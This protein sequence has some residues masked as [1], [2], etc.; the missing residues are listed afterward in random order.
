VPD[1]SVEVRLGVRV[2]PGQEPAALER[3]IASEGR[4]A[5]R[6]LYLQV[7]EAKDDAAVK[8]AMGSRQRREPRWVATIFGRVRIHRYRVK[9]RTKSFHPLDKELGLHRSEPSRALRALTV[10]LAARMSYRDI[11]MA[12]S[13]ITGE[14]VTYQQ[15]GRLLREKRD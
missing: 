8:A 4:R 5:A 13:Q 1:V 14:A 2:R 12:L 9:H 11:A 7:I 15:L 10:K 3:A 6:E